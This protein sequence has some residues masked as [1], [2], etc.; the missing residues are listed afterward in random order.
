MLSASLIG[1]FKFKA[2]E[3]HLRA[4]NT[5]GSLW[6]CSAPRCPRFPE[7]PKAEGCWIRDLSA[8]KFSYLSR[9]VLGKVARVRHMIAGAG[10]HVLGRMV[11]DPRAKRE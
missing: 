5:L 1:V 10:Q 9:Q 11:A 2:T 8:K 7:F 4:L 6:H 3:Q